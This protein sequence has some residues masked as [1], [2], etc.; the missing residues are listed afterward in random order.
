[1]AR[2]VGED[3]RA[4]ARSPGSLVAVAAA[5]GSCSPS[6]AVAEERDGDLARRLVFP[7]FEPGIRVEGSPDYP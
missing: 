6:R 5:D 7:D 2:D 4:V 1:M 3:S